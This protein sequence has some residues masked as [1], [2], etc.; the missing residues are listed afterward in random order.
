MSVPTLFKIVKNI[1][2]T[3]V[4][5][6]VDEADIGQVKVRQCVSFIVNVYSQE[7]F[8]GHVT[9]VHSS[10]TTSSNVVACTVIIEVG[11]S[12]EKLKSGLTATIAIYTSELKG[13]TI[14]PAKATNFMPDTGVLLRHHIQEDITAEAPRVRYGRREDKY[15]WVV[16]AD[17]T[18]A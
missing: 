17:D 13:V 15:V 18:L 16:N 2:H 5:V 11:D 8:V 12:D 7:E 14:V 1:G 6:N 4:K 9:Q 10:P 3:Q